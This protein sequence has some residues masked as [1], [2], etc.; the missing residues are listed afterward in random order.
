LRGSFLIQEDK[1]KKL[2]AIITIFISFNVFANNMKPMQIAYYAK[3][4]KTDYS[5]YTKTMNSAE[6][7]AFKA[8]HLSEKE[9][10]FF[11]DHII[12][13]EDKNKTFLGLDLDILEMG[14]SFVSLGLSF[15]PTN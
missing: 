12:Y 7:E 6:I 2:I 4:N 5:F 8:C 10:N 9:I 3:E 11:N 1:M 13:P 15:I 14:L